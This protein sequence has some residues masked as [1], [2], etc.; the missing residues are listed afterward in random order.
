MRIKA[1][2]CTATVA[3][4]G[5]SAHGAQ[6][7]TN[8]GFA[9]PPCASACSYK[10]G[11][12][13]DAWRVL[14]GPAHLVN[15]GSSGL[16][17]ADGNSQ[18]LLLTNFQYIEEPIGLP[19]SPPPSAQ[20]SFALGTLPNSPQLPAVEVLIGGVVVALYSGLNSIPTHRIAWRQVTFTASPSWGVGSIG[21]IG[22]KGSVVAI[23]NVQVSLVPLPASHI[24]FGSAVAGLAFV[25][26]RKN[27]KCRSAA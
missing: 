14:I 9:D 16:E 19:G 15:S 4:W 1:A 10:T 6:L 12:N 23:D 21:F 27:R 7:V 5:W 8:G 25:A 20:I 17:D 26:Q 3:L 18:Y 22:L 2:L 11:D 24:L 13:L